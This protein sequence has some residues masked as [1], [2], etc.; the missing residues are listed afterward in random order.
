MVNRRPER[1]LVVDDEKVVRGF[2]TRYLE[3][4]GFEVESVENGAAALG[5]ARLKAFDFCLLDIRMPEMDGFELL[6]ELRKILSGAKF[7]MMTGYVM[8]DIWQKMQNKGIFASIRK[9]F[10]PQQIK[11]LLNSDCAQEQPKVNILVIDGDPQVLKFFQG[12]LKEAV[13]EVTAA[14]A[15]P[16]A[17]RLFDKKVFDLVFLDIS[18]KDVNGT[19]LY[20]KFKETRPDLNVILI[21]V[22][23]KQVIDSGQLKINSFIE[24]PF[25]VDKIMFE[26]NKVRKLRGL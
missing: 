3:L 15:G 12:L 11:D 7:I 25:E 14:Q 5:I 18:L 22:D 10:D 6:E 13:F 19:Q 24:K 16:D 21:T 17:L 1:I 8:D 23:P 2:L 4:E 9:P 20:V 26:I